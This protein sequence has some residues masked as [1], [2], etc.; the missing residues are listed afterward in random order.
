MLQV[1]FTI[2]LLADVPQ[3]GATR[4]VTAPELQEVSLYQFTWTSRSYHLIVYTP[5]S[6]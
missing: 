4:D 3:S 1:L 6:Y 2:S 5:V